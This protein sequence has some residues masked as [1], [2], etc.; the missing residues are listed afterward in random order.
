MLVFLP[1]IILK[2]FDREYLFQIR[3][4]QFLIGLAFSMTINKAQG[5]TLDFV[6]IYLFI[7]SFQS[8]SILYIALSGGKQ[9]E[10]IKIMVRD[11]G[12]QGNFPKMTRKRNVENHTPR[13]LFKLSYSTTQNVH[14]KIPIQKTLI[15]TSL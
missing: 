5:Q 7:Y 11:T 4:M 15:I 8:R 3:R 9:F 2:P 10:D 1:R 14:L 12:E 6:G 13:I